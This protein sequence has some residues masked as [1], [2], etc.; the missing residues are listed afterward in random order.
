MTTGRTRLHKDTY[1][2]S[3]R[4]LA[5]SKAML[6]VPG[7]EQAT[8]LMGTP[9]NLA[10]LASDGFDAGALTG[11]GANDLLLAVRAGSP[12]AAEAAL[13]RA[14]QVLL[15]GG[16]PVDGEGPGGG[17]A[18]AG[19]ATTTGRPRTLEEA[20]A[21]LPGANV[22][23]VSVPGPYA[24]LEA[25]KALSAGLHVL[26]FSD[27]V[28]VEDEVALKARAG[29]L[30]LLLMGPGAGTAMLGGVGLGFANA[31]SRGPVGIV[32]AAGTGAQEAMSLLD[33][34]GVGVA[35]VL[36][37]GGR[38][39]SRAVGGSM[40]MQAIG[41]L[42]RDPATRVILLVSKPPAADIAAKVLGMATT[43]PLVAAL[44][45]LN[46]PV[47]LPP[48]VRVAGSLEQ[49]ALEVLEVL[50]RPRPELGTGLV[51]AAR[52][53]CSR[54]APERRAVRGLFSGGT[55]CFEALVLLSGRLGAVHS[56]TPLR[57][58]WGLPAPPG[59]HV[60]LDVGEEDYTRGR[61]H[62]MIDPGTRT[63]LI[64]REGHDPSTAVVLLDVVLGHGAHPDPA[65]E[66]V[67]ACAG[68]LA[69]AGGPQVVVYVLGTGRDPQGDLAQRRAFEE[70][71]CIVAPT[72][73][74]A[75]L[76]AA[77]IAARRPEIAGEPG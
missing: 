10:Q 32:A 62:P 19:P 65:A 25:H 67:P 40:T 75:A 37:V 29:A 41:H 20:L 22:A 27:N 63:G 77:A 57:D 11:A 68:V 69:Q 43:K 61:P 55:L 52:R 5:G 72:G 64:R 44:P 34:W 8:A 3:V 53:A 66:L 45:G 74:R 56:N 39:L 50:G 73:A 13:A 38:D 71:G 49:G 36:G 28:P 35:E 12:E 51:G 16:P 58:G 4:L 15:G 9:A 23:V 60:C 7:V 54:L 48:G 30:G 2:D 33:R 24:A 1:L 6:G 42:E 76:V 26:L 47:P 17:L 14:E 21:A 70:A 18:G 59:A 31:V 46:E